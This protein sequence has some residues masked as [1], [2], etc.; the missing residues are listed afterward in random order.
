LIP[1]GQYHP[2]SLLFNGHVETIYPSLLRRVHTQPYRR[3]RIYTPDDDFLDIDWLKQQSK[4]LVILSH[5]LEGNASRSYVRGMAKAFFEIGF[6]VLAW[7]YRG[8]AEEMNR[9]VRFY[10]SGATDDLDVVVHHAERFYDELFLVGFS[11]G[12][13][14]T[15]KYLGE[16]GSHLSAKL[17]RSVVFSVPM[18]LYTSCLRISSPD[19]WIY[20]R[21]F[22]RSLKNKVRTKARIMPEINIDGIDK[23]DNLQA[24]D[25]RYTAP[26]H[27]FRDAVHYYQ[28]SSAI[29]Y[30]DNIAIPTL[31]VNAKNDPFLSPECSPVKL[32]AGHSCVKLE[33]PARGGHVGFTLFNKFGLY[34][35]ELKALE[36]IS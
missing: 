17:K 29:R 30:V 34:W 22:L 10:H 13:N 7:N 9:Q 1:A 23:I 35:S 28:E 8:C 33:T 18:D 4:K 26:L 16:R 14:L 21:R 27:G 15:L 24:F 19:N 5:G 32:L 6:D 12:G 11:L 31:I 36:F 20:S 25:D 3:E 2:P